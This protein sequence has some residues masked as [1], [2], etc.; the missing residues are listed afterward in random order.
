MCETYIEK[1]IFL[2]KFDTNGTIIHKKNGYRSHELYKLPLFL[3]ETREN[4]FVDII[5][6]TNLNV[7]YIQR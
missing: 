5:I 3:S 7:R 1:Y 6:R 2:F 4:A